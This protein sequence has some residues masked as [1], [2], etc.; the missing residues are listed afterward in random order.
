MGW[1]R[2]LIRPSSNAKHVITLVNNWDVHL[3]QLLLVYRTKPHF[4]T[5]ESCCLIGMQDYP[6]RL[7]W[8]HCQACMW[9]T[10]KTTVRS[11]QG[12][13]P[14][15]GRQLNL[16]QNFLQYDK[17]TDPH[18]GPYQIL[19]VRSNTVPMRPVD[20]PEAEAILVNLDRVVQC[21]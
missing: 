7:L 6:Q 14:V 11:S 4:S 10:V 18:R 2:T 19:E 20:L 17:R 12:G 1:L 8:R 21:P 15:Q 9:G 13:C 16:K 5:G 3:Q